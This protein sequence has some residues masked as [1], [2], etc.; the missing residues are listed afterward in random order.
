[1]V[2]LQVIVL[3]DECLVEVGTEYTKLRVPANGLLL[4]VLDAGEGLAL[5]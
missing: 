3:S 2:L 5:A 4:C 1:M